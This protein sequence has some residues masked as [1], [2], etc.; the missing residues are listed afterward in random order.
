VARR[1]TRA[2]ASCAPR[3]RRSGPAREKRAVRRNPDNA[4]SRRATPLIL[5]GRK[6]TGSPA[7]DLKS[8]TS[9]ALAFSGNLSAVVPAQACTH[10]PRSV[11]MISLSTVHDVWV[12]ACRGDDNE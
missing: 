5:R 1:E 3:T 8:G 4:P 9:I 2:H 11:L 6:E 10:N 7:P 12:S